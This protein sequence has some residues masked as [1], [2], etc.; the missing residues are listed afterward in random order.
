[1]L[2]CEDKNTTK[3]TLTNYLNQKVIHKKDHCIIRTISWAV[4]MLIFV[5]S[6]FINCYYYYSKH[7]LKNKQLVLP[8]YYYL[9][10]WRLLYFALL[11]RRHNFSLVARYLLKFTHC[12]LLVVK[13][14]VTPCKICSLLVAE[15]ARRKK[16]LVTRFRSCSLQKNH[17][18][19]VAKNH[20]LLFAKFALCSSQSW[21]HFLQ[22]YLKMTP[23]QAF[24]CNFCEILRAPIL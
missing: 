9:H 13:S 6:H 17:S 1:M 19:L 2:L 11:K 22:L 24:S 8:P 21:S 20:S 18:L 23:A 7:S 15:V 12:L 10:N 5:S 14:L 3:T 16:S 4:Y